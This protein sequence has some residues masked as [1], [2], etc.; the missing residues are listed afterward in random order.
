MLKSSLYSFNI[1]SIYSVNT[2][3]TQSWM[4]CI[5]LLE[6]NYFTVFVLG[7]GAFKKAMLDPSRKFQQI[8]FFKANKIHFVQTACRCSAHSTFI[9]S[10]DS[11]LNKTARSRVALFWV[12][13]KEPCC[14]LL[15]ACATHGKIHWNAN[16]KIIITD[17]NPFFLIF[18]L[19]CSTADYQCRVSSRCTAE[20]FSYTYT[21]IHSSHSSPP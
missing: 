13:G 1:H 20:W 16:D 21:C 12:S 14:L 7:S 9:S 17:N 2:S 4:Q 8:F 6:Y 18:I 11:V 15:P 10:H 5:F 19:Y 3:K